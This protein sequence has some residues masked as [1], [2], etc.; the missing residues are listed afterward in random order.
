ML[1]KLLIWALL[2]IVPMT[3]L[4]MVCL[5]QP[6]GVAVPEA[7]ASAGAEC[8]ETCALPGKA[9]RRSTPACM[10]LAESCSLILV[11]TVAVLP[12]QPAVRTLPEI[13]RFEYPGQTCYSAPVLA[14]QG[15]PPKA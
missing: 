1:A 6:G 12:A 5:D 11:G 13:V 4:R 10:L 3:G 2:A 9:A 15:P 7:G 14:H 8:D